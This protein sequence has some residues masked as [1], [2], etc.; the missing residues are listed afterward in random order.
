MIKIAIIGGSG[1]EKAEILQNSKN[2][3]VD[4][5]FGK[6]SSDIKEG[7][8]EERKVFLLNRHGV[9]HSI[10]PS[11]VNYKANIWA[12]KSLGC[13]HILASTAVGSLRENIKPGDLIFPDQLIDFTKTRQYTF[14][15]KEKI[16]HTPMSEPFCSKIITELSKLADELNMDYHLNKTVVTIEG[17]RFSTKAE[18][19][20]FRSLGADIINMSTS[21]EAALAREQKIHY[22][23]IGMATDYDCWKEDEESVSWDQIQKVMKDNS[24]KVT[25]IILRIISKLENWED[26][27]SF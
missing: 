27:C 8:I 21:P 24:S 18:S 14:F 3:T 16:V 26:Q 19:N 20:M 5:P 9:T 22:S 17:P 4:T 13:T 1:L 12:L 7:S 2:L 23:A 10:G 25:E 11:Q 15:D 6:P